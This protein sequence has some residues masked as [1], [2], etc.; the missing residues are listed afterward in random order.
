MSDADALAAAQAAANELA[1]R[2]TTDQT[3]TPAERANLAADLK[4]A[5][6]RIDQLERA[7]Q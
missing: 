4:D 7:A 2:Y 3:L 6:R 5:A 1:D